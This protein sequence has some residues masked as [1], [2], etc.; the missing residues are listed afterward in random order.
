MLPIGG[1][2]TKVVQL[3]QE[4]FQFGI[5]SPNLDVIAW[6]IS[7]VIGLACLILWLI[8]HLDDRLYNMLIKK[9]TLGSL[10]Y[11]DCV[12]MLKRNINTGKAD[13][14]IRVELKN[15]NDFLVRFRA[16]L[17][18][19]IN[20]KIFTN[21]DGV[22]TLQFYG[23]VNQSHSTSLILK[24]AD[25]PVSPAESTAMNLSGDF[26]YDVIYFA[27]PSGHRT[28]RTM[29]HITFQSPIILKNEPGMHAAHLNFLF[30]EEKEE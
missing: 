19:Q 16:T 4:F 21:A 14:E 10:H 2:D 5:N 24:I 13:A 30:T 1:L 28:H 29:K 23:Y 15:T 12:P 9:P 6:S 11:V 8:F 7:G 22:D 27:A 20:G 17:R 26:I 3:L 18:G 25:I